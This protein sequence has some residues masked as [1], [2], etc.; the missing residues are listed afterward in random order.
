[1]FFILPCFFSLYS[2]FP[3]RIA[4]LLKYLSLSV[5]CFRLFIQRRWVKV[6]PH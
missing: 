1:M 5:L 2:S 3:F 4:L 6:R